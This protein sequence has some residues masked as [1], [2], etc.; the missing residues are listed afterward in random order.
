M[1]EV[2][3]KFTTQEFFNV[4]NV[5]RDRCGCDDCEALA[6]KI[7]VQYRDQHEQQ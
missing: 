7:L 6:N 1:P 4:V 5:M 3:I 2:T